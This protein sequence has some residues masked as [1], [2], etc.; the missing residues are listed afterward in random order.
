MN[1]E[2]TQQ[3]LRKIYCWMPYR[4]DWSIGRTNRE[5]II[6]TFYKELI[7]SIGSSD[8]FD[9]YNSEEGGRANYLEFFCYPTGHAFYSGNAIQV[10]ISLCSPIVAYGQNEITK[11]ENS[12]GW[13][14]MFSADA[15]GIITDE[16][17]KQIELELLKLFSNNKLGLL[18]T[19]LAIQAMPK[20]VADEVQQENHNEGNQ[21]LHGIFQKID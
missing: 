3:E 9:S 10:C 15:V 17:L 19:E 11:N 6:S 8:Q 21:I 2:L 4:D 18:A 13:N 14:P 5:D 20:E 16:S 12:F 1:I 7:K